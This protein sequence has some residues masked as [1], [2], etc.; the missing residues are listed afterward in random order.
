MSGPPSLPRHV[1]ANGAE[2]WGWA[3]RL[4]EWQQREQKIADLRADIAQRARECG[5]CRFWMCGSDCPREYHDKG[6]PRGPSMKAPIC[7]KYEMKAYD[8]KRQ[9][10]RQAELAELADLIAERDAPEHQSDTP[11]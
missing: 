11:S 1:S 2:I 7:G 9:A 5:S 3:D 8:V 6:R 10:E 4:S